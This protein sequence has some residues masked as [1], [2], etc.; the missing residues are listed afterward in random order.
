M[1]QKPMITVTS[2]IHAPIELIWKLWNDPKAIQ[3]WN[4]IND[5]WHNPVVENDPRAGGKFLY[6]MG[7]KDGSFNFDFTG[8]YDEVVEHK[9]ITYTLNSG[10]TA[11]ITFSEGNPVIL[12]EAFEPDDK[13]SV[14]EQRNF[15][16]A[17]VDSFKSYVEEKVK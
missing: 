10:R 1:N 2:E 12:T 7:T 14:E 3:Q 13:P 8:T 15:C 17:V 11:K 9:L 4:N 5:D 16:Q 6:R